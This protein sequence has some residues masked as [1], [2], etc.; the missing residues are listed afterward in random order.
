[1]WEH[2]Y[3]EAGVIATNPLQQGLKPAE[4]IRTI[5]RHLCHCD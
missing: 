2:Q 3:P 1:M 5:A 4:P